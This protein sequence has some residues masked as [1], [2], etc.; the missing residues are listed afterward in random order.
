MMIQK[1]DIQIYKKETGK[2]LQNVK[3]ALKNSI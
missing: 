2:H 1:K 3:T